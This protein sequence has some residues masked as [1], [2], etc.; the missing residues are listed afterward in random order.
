VDTRPEQGQ[1]G[2]FGPPM[3]APYAT[4]TFPLSTHPTCKIPPTAAAYSLNF[5]AIPV[6]TLDFLSTWPSG[7]SYP[8]VSTLNATQGGV[9]ANAAIVPAG[10]N[11]GIDVVAG[12]NTHFLIDVN[13]YYAPQQTTIGTSLLLPGGSTVRIA[14]VQI[15]N[16]TSQVRVLPGSQFTVTMD[17][18]IADPAPATPMSQIEIGFA[19]RSTKEGCAFDGNLAPLPGMVGTATVTLTAPAT[20]GIYYIAADRGQDSYCKATNSYWWTGARN[21]S[22]HIGAITVY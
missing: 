4:R 8:S 16:T 20:T 15:N 1:T 10:T 9:V 18:Q 3:L 12:K 7:G 19:D 5:T 22:H 11:G 17:Y 6:T 14:N 13:G 2:A 21:P